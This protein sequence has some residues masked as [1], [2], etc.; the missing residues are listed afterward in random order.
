LKKEACFSRPTWRHSFKIKI[1][2]YRNVLT[3]E[4]WQKSATEW[5]RDVPAAIGTFMGKRLRADIDFSE[6]GTTE[7][8]KQAGALLDEILADLPAILRKA[9]AALA[10][11]EQGTDRDYSSHISNPRIWILEGREEDPKAWTLVVERD[12][13]Q[14]FGWH[15]EFIGSDL[16]E[17]WAG[18]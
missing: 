12:D 5:V 14:D 7:P 6:T 8:S 13:W 18:D 1:N 15:I 17:L 4:T 11:Y 2:G 16:V 10:E 9:E 3:D